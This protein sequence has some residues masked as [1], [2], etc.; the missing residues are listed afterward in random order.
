[1]W[2]PW[3]SRVLVLRNF[4]PCPISPCHVQFWVGFVCM[5]NNKTY[6]KGFPKLLSPNN[7][8]REILLSTEHENEMLISVC[9]CWPITCWTS[10]TGNF[11]FEK[12][13][14]RTN[15]YFVCHCW[16]TRLCPQN[17]APAI[18]LGKKWWPTVLEVEISCNQWGG[19]ACTHEQSSLFL[20]EWGGGEIGIF[21]FFH[22]FPMCSPRCSQ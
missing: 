16:K 10:S 3:K 12:S 7:T 8:R 11:S 15:F 20:F 17:S 18:S 2:N 5:K 14:T 21:C 9:F 19:S 22:L 6:P 1:M 4:M 13:N